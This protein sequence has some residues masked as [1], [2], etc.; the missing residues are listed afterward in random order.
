MGVEMALSHGNRGF[1]RRNVL[2]HVAAQKRRGSEPLDEAQFHCRENPGLGRRISCKTGKW[3]TIASGPIPEAPGDTWNAVNKA[4][5]RGGRGLPGGF[6]LPELL[7]VERGVRSLTSIPRFNRKRILSWADAHFRRHGEW[8]GIDS[9]VIPEAPEET[10]ERVHHALVQGNRGLRGGTSLPQFLAKHRGKR[11][12][13][14]L[15]PL[16]SKIILGW[17][18][19]HFHRKGYWPTCH[20][21]PVEDGPGETWEAIDAAL[22][23][24][25]RNLPGGSSL[26]QLLVKKRGV[27]TT[28][29]GNPSLPGNF[30]P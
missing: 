14:A 2:G 13:S 29:N 28:G 17:A 5:N 7:A 26:Y 4:L 6:S 8:P 21:G 22:R 18:D 16:T 3:P 23:V 27:K 25:R 11:I 24:G 30:A 1:P 9:G 20:G 12:L 19:A 10:W 15:P